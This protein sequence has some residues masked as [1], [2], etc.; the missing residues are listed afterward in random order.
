MYVE[1]IRKNPIGRGLVALASDY[2]DCWDFPG[3][4]K[5]EAL[6]WLKPQESCEVFLHG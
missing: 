1:S 6:Q 4:E 5:D 3:S 2:L